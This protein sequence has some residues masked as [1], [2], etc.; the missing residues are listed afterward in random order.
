MK[1]TDGSNIL[2]PWPLGMTNLMRDAEIA[3]KA[4]RNAVNVN[5]TRAGAAVRRSGYSQVSAGEYHSLWSDG[6]GFGVAVKGQNLIRLDVSSSG[7]VQETVLTDGMKPGLPVSYLRV[8]A[9]I[10]YSNGDTNGRIMNGVRVPW[11]IESAKPPQLTATTTGGMTAGRYQVAMTYVAANGEE[12]GTSR[13]TAVDV[14]DGGGIALSSIVQPVGSNVA[15]IRLYVT[16]PNG[17]LFYEYGDIP[18]GLSTFVLSASVTLGKELQTWGNFPPP[19]GT[20]IELHNSFIL[21]A[22]DKWLWYTEPYNFNAFKPLN[23]Y[24]FRGPISI[25]SSLNNSLVAVVADV[26]Y[27]LAGPDPGVF[28][29]SESFQYKAIPGTLLTLPQRRKTWV[30]ERGWTL[31]DPQG[32]GLTE[33]LSD[34]VWPETANQ[35]T[36]YYRKENGDEFLLATLIEGSASKSLVQDY[37]DAEVIRR[38]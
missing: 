23:A 8:N 1:E 35:G 21:I 3:D 26:H 18:L 38:S 36:S 30:T 4:L 34:R 28:D 12:G 20:A 25:V 31:Y 15:S 6:E 33:V 37:F 9:D 2:G 29:M 14:P 17:G 24:Q 7:A 11:G 32:G 5:I 16:P 13:A 10:Y 22:K 27:L 19:A